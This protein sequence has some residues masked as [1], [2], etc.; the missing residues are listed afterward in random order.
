[1]MHHSSALPVLV[2]RFALTLYQNLNLARVNAL[3]AE[4][5]Q[6]T[7]LP[8]E[9][10]AIP[11]ARDPADGLEPPHPSHARL[12]RSAAEALAQA[13]S[14]TTGWAPF[15]IPDIRFSC[16]EVL[17]I[18]LCGL[19]L[20]SACEFKPKMISC[21]IDQMMLVGRLNVNSEI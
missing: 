14:T 2:V 20:N 15:R 11:E 19:V 18:L 10:G 12:A 1:M 4:S 6:H 21:E 13:A 16:V 8:L 3:S 5:A 7:T 17:C 9:D